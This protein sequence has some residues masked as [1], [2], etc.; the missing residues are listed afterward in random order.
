MAG[1][2]ANDQTIA[3]RLKASAASTDE[4]VWQMPLERAY[5]KQLDSNIA[6][7]RN[8][9]GVP[10]G[11]ITAAL[12]LNEFVGDTPWAHVDMAG[13]MNSDGDDGWLSKGATGYGARLL[14]DLALNFSS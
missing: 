9:G 1:V 8:I 6:D 10:A 12:F 5:R 13:T 14:I 7:F 4:A 2:F 3:D 11:S